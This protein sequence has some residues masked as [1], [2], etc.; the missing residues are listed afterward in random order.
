MKDI[1]FIVIGQR[2]KALRKAKKVSVKELA[3]KTNLSAALVSKVENFRTL[4]SLTTLLVITEALEIEM[5]ELVKDI[6][7]RKKK[8]QYTLIRAEDQSTIHKENSEGFLYRQIL[9]QSTREGL[10]QCCHLSLEKGNKRE[11]VST[12]GEQILY[13]LKGEL[14]FWVGDNKITL[15][16]GDSLQFDGRIPHLPEAKKSKVEL[17]VIYLIRHEES[18]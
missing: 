7:V 9:S 4:P 14:L 3:E 11:K 16:P 10:M 1:E 12:D 13:V 6:G 15:K 5:S 18:A 17:L 2:I 8:T